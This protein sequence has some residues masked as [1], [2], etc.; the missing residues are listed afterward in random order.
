MSVDIDIDKVEQ[1][2]R[3]LQRKDPEKFCQLRLFLITKGRW[4]RVY[5]G[6]W[7]GMRE[8]VELSYIKSLKPDR[9]K[10]L[11]FFS[12]LEVIINELI[13][14]KVFGLFSTEGYTLDDILEF[15]DFSYRL[16]LLKKWEIFD[17]NLVDKISKV[18]KVRNQFAHRW[19]EGEVF[20][21]E[22]VEDGKKVKLT[23][24]EN[25]SQFKNDVEE[26]W[27]EIIERYEI[28]ER[29]HFGKLITQLGDYN[30]F[31]AI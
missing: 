16:R 3:E 31:L 14:S 18:A 29:K 7:S 23:I 17:N 9:G 2:A 5:N 28:E 11:D 22:K 15:V 30:S 27:L 10:I 1:L 13:Q 19:S 12:K 25:F 21:G 8:F 20:Y 24:V 6:A 4:F 26:I